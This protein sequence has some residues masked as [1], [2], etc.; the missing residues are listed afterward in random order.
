M[1]DDFNVNNNFF[2]V[3]DSSGRLK[4]IFVSPNVLNLSKRQL[5]VAEISLLSKGL[6]FVPTPNFVNRAILKEELEIF[7]R[8]L[9][10]KWHFRNEESTG[11]FNPF[12]RKSKFNPKGK[13]AA[14][15]MYLSRLEEEILA[16]DTKLG[17][18]NLTREEKKALKSLKDDV[19]IIIKEADKGSAVV[20]WDREDYLQEASKQLG[21]SDTYEEV[22]GDCV[23]PLIKDI[24]QS[25]SRIHTRGIFQKRRWTI[26]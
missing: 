16:I 6:K 15:E 2:N 4:G 26:F 14:I 24:K 23:S 25:L 10:L 17:Y 8:K 19:D 12:R 5:S 22:F 1:P 21:D 13:D 18:S 7:G 3:S 20:V 9:R 11:T